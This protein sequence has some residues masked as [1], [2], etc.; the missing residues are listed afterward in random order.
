MGHRGADEP[1]DDFGWLTAG[2]VFAGE[3]VVETVFTEVVPVLLIVA[4]VLVVIGRTELT[5]LS[6]EIGDLLTAASRMERLTDLQ[7][8]DLSGAELRTLVRNCQGDNSREIDPPGWVEEFAGL[9]HE[10]LGGNPFSAIECSR[11][12]IDASGDAPAAP[13]SAI[14]SGIPDV[15]RARVAGLPQQL[16]Q[17]AEAAATVGDPIA[18]DLLS[19]ML[20]IGPWEIAEALD[21]L[22]A[23]RILISHKGAIRFVHHLIA[24]V[25]YD[26]LP[27]AKREMLHEK[28]ALTTLR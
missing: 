1:P 3:Q 13:F 22:V 21:E 23:K 20:D 7:V 18:P 28:A 10:V 27:P 6:S 24:E 14:R 25:I 8:S 5:A 12:T 4:L 15:V 9:I 2:E 26:S 16:R 19:R 11:L 17:L